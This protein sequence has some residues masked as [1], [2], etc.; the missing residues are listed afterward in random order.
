MQPVTS[1]FV[2]ATIDPRFV[3]GAASTFSAASGCSTAAATARASARR[4]SKALGLDL[5]VSVQLGVSPLLAE[6]LLRRTPLRL[7]RL[8]STSSSIE[9][10]RPLR[11]AGLSRGL[12]LGS[13][14]AN[15]NP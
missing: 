1:G 15:G 13:L 3:G 5:S 6:E 4:L 9:Q 8:L 14:S 12:T 10:A 2:S 7:E 11:R